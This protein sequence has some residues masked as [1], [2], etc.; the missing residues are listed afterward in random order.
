MVSAQIK[1]MEL[2]REMEPFYILALKLVNGFLKG[3]DFK[4]KVMP[5]SGS[6]VS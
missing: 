6:G 3:G 4:A 2:F 5:E 1:K